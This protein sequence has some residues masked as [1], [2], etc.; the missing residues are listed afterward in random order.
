MS[1]SRCLETMASVPDSGI[2]FTLNGQDPTEGSPI[3]REPLCLI[4]GGHGSLGSE[5]RDSCWHPDVGGDPVRDS[6]RGEKSRPA[7]QCRD[8]GAGRGV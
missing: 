2:C 6:G 5:V 7:Q 8:R 1:W 3:S 4:L